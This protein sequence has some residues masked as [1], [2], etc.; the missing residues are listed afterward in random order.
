MKVLPCTRA[1]CIRCPDGLIKKFK[2]RFLV[3]GDYQTEG[4]DFFETWSP[5]V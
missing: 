5:V 4:V 3:H 2:A 1:F